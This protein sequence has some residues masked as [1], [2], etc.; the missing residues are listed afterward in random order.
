MRTN[1]PSPAAASVDPSGENWSLPN[2]ATVNTSSPRRSERI[3][4]APVATS[5]S[6]TMP[7]SSRV[8]MVVLSGE[9]ATPMMATGCPVR[10]RT[11]PVF[12][13]HSRN[14]LS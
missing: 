10:V 9:N 8:P 1:G 7:S 12:T 11:S 4:L 3:R 5:Q 14:R 2:G 6:R 13:S